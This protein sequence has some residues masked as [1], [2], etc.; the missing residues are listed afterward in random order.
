MLNITIENE[1]INQI[2]RLLP[3]MNLELVNLLKLNQKLNKMKKDIF[4]FLSEESL[5][6]RM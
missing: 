5:I 3:P 6:R 1:K 2:L 4:I